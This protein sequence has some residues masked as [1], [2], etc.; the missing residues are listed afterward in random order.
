MQNGFVLGLMINLVLECWKVNLINRI[1]WIISS[2]SMVLSTSLFF[3]CWF[4]CSFVWLVGC[5][6]WWR[7][8]KALGIMCDW[9]SPSERVYLFC[10]HNQNISRYFA[11]LLYNWSINTF[12][13]LSMLDFYTK[14]GIEGEKTS[15]FK[16]THFL[17][18]IHLVKICNIQSQDNVLAW[19][20]LDI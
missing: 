16:S 17:F 19:E 2:F 5:F 15:H 12:L 20:K 1:L 7:R 11:S 8:V 4:F 18:N 9:F 10:D 3:W 6:F 13:I 14:E